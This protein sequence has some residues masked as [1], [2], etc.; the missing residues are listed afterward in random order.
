MLQVV[1]AGD[2]F[3]SLVFGQPFLFKTIASQ[4]FPFPGC[5]ALAAWIPGCPV[6]AAWIFFAAFC[7]KYGPS[8]CV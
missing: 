3:N 5:P 7:K 4:P 6:L 8:T 2:Y 1:A